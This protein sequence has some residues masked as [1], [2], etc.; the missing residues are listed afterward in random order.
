MNDLADLVRAFRTH[1]DR[2]WTLERMADEV[3]TSRQN[4]ENLEKGRVKMPRFL[5]DLA[6]AMGTTTDALLGQQ[7]AYHPATNTVPLSVRERPVS[8][9]G[10]R[11]AREETARELL[12]L[13]G[14]L[15]AAV[16]PNIRPALATNMQSWALEG[17]PRHYEGLIAAILGE[18]PG[19]QA[20]AGR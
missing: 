3:G 2:N 9:K 14:R 5:P 6:K 10:P 11:E 12:A 4:I 1:P 17:G 18:A 20:A 15:I 19:K 13:L 16:P 7:Q 8:Y